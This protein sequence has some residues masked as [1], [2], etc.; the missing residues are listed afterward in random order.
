MSQTQTY[1]S[2]K[3]IEWG[4]KM[5]RHI[6]S[7]SLAMTACASLISTKANAATL[8]AIPVNGLQKNP[9]DEMKFLL[10]LNP[11]SPTSNFIEYLGIGSWNQDQSELSRRV[12]T[13]H[14]NFGNVNTLGYLMGNTT[15]VAT[16]TFDVYNPV[17]DGGNDLFNVTAIYREI[18]GGNPI[19]GYIYGEIQ[20][21]EVFETFD[22]QPIERGVPEPLTI[23]GAATALGYGVILKRKYSKNTKS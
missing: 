11:A 22:V 18:L 16:L 3:K 10:V 1:G 4:V 13:L 20:L 14:E 23:L 9:G 8:T 21:A 17:K 6:I 19:N 12:P 5:L 15:T 7:V 2:L